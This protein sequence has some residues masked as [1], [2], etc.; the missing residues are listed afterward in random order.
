MRSCNHAEL[1]NNCWECTCDSLRAENAALKAR[2]KNNCGLCVEGKPC[3]QERCPN[4]T[5][6]AADYNALKAECDTI[7]ATNAGLIKLR[8]MDA[9][10]FTTWVEKYDSLR[11]RMEAL[12]SALKQYASDSF[13]EYGCGC[14]CVPKDADGH[15]DWDNPSDATAGDLARRTLAAADGKKDA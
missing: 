1:S 15:R 10:S 8:E 2:L 4:D 11:S 9:E 14:C 7:R 5:V 13:W 3:N 12:E 6:L